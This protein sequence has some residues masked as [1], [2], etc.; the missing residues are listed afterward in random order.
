MGDDVDVDDIQRWL[1]KILEDVKAVCDRH[2]IRFCLAW[3]SL[4][5]AI[6]HHG[7]IPWDDDIDIMM[8]RADYERFFAVRDELGPD[9]MIQDWRTEPEYWNF[10]PKVRLLSPKPYT[11]EM[12][13]DVTTRNGMF[14]DIF[15]L[16]EVPA[17]T[18]LSQF[19]ISALLAGARV[20]LS[21]KQYGHND[22]HAIVRALSYGARLV[23][24]S[25]LAKVMLWGATR[26]DGAGCRW[27]VCYG[28]DLRHRRRAVPAAT[29]RDLIQVPFEHTQMPVP[30]EYD[31]LLRSRYGNYL[32]LPPVAQ[33][34]HT[35]TFVP[36]LDQP[37]QPDAS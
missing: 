27:M 19:A 35:H 32:Q 28:G 21:A 16:D 17:P 33:R 20:V 30:R 9:Y 22:P 6:R 1:L 37:G 29:Y 34:V 15:L 31:R 13:A 18:S 8:T 26:W 23:R 24:K 7:F 2:D 36:N 25:T 5:G 3:G 10:H 12:I 4:L 14:L 11:E